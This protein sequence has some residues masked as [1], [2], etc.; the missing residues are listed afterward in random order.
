[1]DDWTSVSISTSTEVSR[2]FKIE[3]EA[4]LL[5]AISKR[6]IKRF[7]RYNC[8]SAAVSDCLEK[9]LPDVGDSMGTH[10]KLNIRS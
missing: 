1:L 2:E 8:N 6:W 7:G 10:R 5:K 3:V 4:G 9:L